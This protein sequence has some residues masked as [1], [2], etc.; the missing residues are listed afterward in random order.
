MKPG[1]EFW[2][3]EA[4]ERTT[5]VYEYNLKEQ[6]VHI[7]KFSHGDLSSVLKHL[8]IKVISPITIS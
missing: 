1:H 8:H 5:F 4:K 6:G 3:Q 2:A 7:T